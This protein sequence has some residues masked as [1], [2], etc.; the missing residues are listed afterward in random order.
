M[1]KD[2]LNRRK[3][4]QRAREVVEQI[5]IS[6]PAKIDMENRS[7]TNKKLSQK[8]INKKLDRAFRNSQVQISNINK[9]MNLGIYG[10]ARL[11]K[12]IQSQL[13]MLDYTEETTE[14]FV[15]QFTTIT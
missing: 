15:E 14:F 9:D 10:K 12:A 1:I 5:S 7:N 8:K 6:Y 11:Y 13:I 4:D 3:I 2:F